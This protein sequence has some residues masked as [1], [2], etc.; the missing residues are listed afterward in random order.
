MGRTYLRPREGTWIPMT[1]R[2]RHAP[3]GAY[4]ERCLSSGSSKFLSGQQPKLRKLVLVY[5]FSSIR[6]PFIGSNATPRLIGRQA[7][8]SP[9]IRV[10][11]R[12]HGCAGVGSA[13]RLHWSRTSVRHRT[14]N[15][16]IVRGAREHNL[17][18][19]DVQIPRDKFTVI[20]G[21]S[22]SGKPSPRDA[23]GSG[24]QSTLAFDIL[25][26]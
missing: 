16:I 8:N 12:R 5:W 18:S 11:F 21:I 13:A 4:S 22:G 26:A 2:F 24:R 20:T 17:K 19:I 9:R 3:C 23:E 10:M 25:F 7:S 6:F 15:K 14:N 1:R